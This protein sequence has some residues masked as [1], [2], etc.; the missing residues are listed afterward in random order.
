MA[1]ITFDTHLFVKKLKEAGF[2]HGIS[3]NEGATNE[4]GYTALPGGFRNPDGSF[5]NIV[6]S[7]YGYTST[8]GIIF[9]LYNS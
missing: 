4:S 3:T 1:T 7:T 9:G 5:A 8:A 2:M 6:K